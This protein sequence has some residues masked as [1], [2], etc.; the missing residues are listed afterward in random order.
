MYKTCA[1]CGKIHDFNHTCYVKKQVRGKTEADKFRA[2]NKWHEKSKSIR[3]RDLNLCRCCL[4]NIY[5]TELRY[6]FNKLGVHHIVPLEE[7]L[8][9]GLDDS[10]LI[11]LCSYHHEL[12]EHNVIPREILFKLANPNCNLAEIKQEVEKILIPPTIKY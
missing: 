9:R 5:N 1:R 8:S 6:N 4:A 2:T 10:N 12:A 7:D 3:E 11:T